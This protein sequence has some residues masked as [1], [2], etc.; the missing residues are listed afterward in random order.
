MQQILRAAVVTSL[1]AL[2]ASCSGSE[3]KKE[4]DH[5]KD[6]SSVATSKLCDGLLGTTGGASL[7]ELTRS[8]K[9]TV[10]AGDHGTERERVAKRMR[11]TEGAGQGSPRLASICT[12]KAPSRAGADGQETARIQYGW[13]PAPRKYSKGHDYLLAGSTI[14]DSYFWSESDRTSIHY[15]CKLPSGHSGTV[16]GRFNG[17]WINRSGAKGV[18]HKYSRILLAS[19]SAMSDAL[20]CVNKPDLAPTSRITDLNHDVPPNKLPEH[21]LPGLPESG[22]VRK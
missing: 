8:Q 1:V 5:H 9:V 6:S 17:G 15:K 18:E 16:T 14:V 21:P 2:L 11:S 10:T 4:E 7:A 19:A 20:G 13:A 22:P 3:D 12:F